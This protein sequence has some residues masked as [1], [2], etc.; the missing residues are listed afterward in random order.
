MKIEYYLILNFF[1][2]LLVR[3]MPRVVNS[4]QEDNYC[5]KSVDRVIDVDKDKEIT[6]SEL[7]HLYIT[8]G[9][10]LKKIILIAEKEIPGSVL[11]VR[12]LNY[13]KLIS[14]YYRHNSLPDNR[15]E[16]YAEVYNKLSLIINLTNSSDNVILANEDVLYGKMV[17]DPNYTVEIK[18]LYCKL[19]N[20][21]IELVEVANSLAESI[22]EE[23]YIHSNSQ[24]VPLKNLLTDHKEIRSI[25]V[26]AYKELSIV[27]NTTKNSPDTLIAQVNNLILSLLIYRERDAFINQKH[28]YTKEL[29]LGNKT[30]KKYVEAIYSFLKNPIHH[31]HLKEFQANDSY[32]TF[33]EEDKIQI[34]QFLQHSS[35]NEMNREYIETGS[36]INNILELFRNVYLTMGIYTA[37]TYLNSLSILDMANTPISTV[38]NQIVN[39]VY[40][41][42][43]LPAYLIVDQL[44]DNLNGFRIS[45]SKLIISNVFISKCINDVIVGLKAYKNDLNVIMSICDIADDPYNGLKYINTSFYVSVHLKNTGDMVPIVNTSSKYDCNSEILIEYILNWVLGQLSPVITIIDGIFASVW[46]IVNVPGYFSLFTNMESPDIKNS[47]QMRFQDN[48]PNI[49]DIFNN[50]Q[51]LTKEEQLI[52][53]GF[54]DINLTSHSEVIAICATYIDYKNSC[55]ENDDGTISI[56]DKAMVNDVLTVIDDIINK[57]SIYLITAINRVF[58]FEEIIQENKVVVQIPETNINIGSEILSKLPG[59][60]NEVI[61]LLYKSVHARTMQ[62][63]WGCLYGTLENMQEND[64]SVDDNKMSQEKEKNKHPNDSKSHKKQAKRAKKTKHAFTIEYAPNFNSV[65][66]GLMI[67]HAMCSAL[68]YEFPMTY[69]RK[70]LL[71]D[72]FLQEQPFTMEA[73]YHYTEIFKRSADFLGVTYDINKYLSTQVM[74]Y[75]N[76]ESYL[77]IER[78]FS[79]SLRACAYMSY[80]IEPL[81]WNEVES[82][83]SR[84]CMLIGKLDDYM[85]LLK[86]ISF[87]W[88]DL[89]YRTF[90]DTVSN[91]LEKLVSC[92]MI[93]INM[94]LYFM[95]YHYNRMHRQSIYKTGHL[96]GCTLYNCLSYLEHNKM[97]FSSNPEQSTTSIYMLDAMASTSN[98]IKSATGIDRTAS[99][100]ES[101]QSIVRLYILNY[102]D[103]YKRF[104]VLKQYNRSIKELYTMYRCIL[105]EICIC[106]NDTSTINDLATKIHQAFSIC[107]VYNSIKGIAYYHLISK[108]VHIGAIDLYQ[109]L[110][111][112]I[113]QLHT[114]SL[115]VIACP[116][117]SV[118]FTAPP[119]IIKDASLITKILKLYQEIKNPQKTKDRPKLQAS[120]PD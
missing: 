69:I 24:I 49:N 92:N 72:Y 63:L 26:R 58:V 34:Y 13:Y 9:G 98:G 48:I 32:P 67:V 68:T 61:R 46:D 57:S 7:H 108:I 112:E 56:L 75:M 3:G 40:P 44:L 95:Q 23:I 8:A 79:V 80:S 17:L 74:L 29:F 53:K 78:L 16:A 117:A 76:L 62:V 104:D 111:A 36:G 38:V 102:P 65:N 10:I 4:Q 109:I 35:Y 115:N 64:D 120:H 37:E 33:T 93:P 97:Y 51:K 39:P 66:N 52:I 31:P 14:K 19:L 77:Y 84:C 18:G 22:S 73:I 71:N 107:T 106:S 55:I 86:T 30:H 6:N 12:L 89:D 94:K 25:L 118:L 11:A 28:R 54:N 70:E 91:K 103:A 41:Y 99:C 45:N 42:Y 87:V 88:C 119:S 1:L 20:Y 5:Y 114:R 15:T 21:C 47:I 96:I 50:N 82:V 2:F 101:M 81:S 110:P 116:D 100:V 43:A 113:Y 83:L 105:Q 85:S 59:I 27:I 90:I 60:K